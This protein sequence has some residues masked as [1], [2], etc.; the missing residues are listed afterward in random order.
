M[1]NEHPL[2]RCPTCLTVTVYQACPT[3][4]SAAIALSQSDADAYI[5]R[6]HAAFLGRLGGLAKSEAKTLAAR[7]NAKRPR[8]RADR[9]ALIAE[10]QTALKAQDWTRANAITRRLADL[11]CDGVPPLTDADRARYTQRKRR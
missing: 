9:L 2:Y 6:G 1:T 5:A 11:P 3:C 4:A 10:R 8:P 7:A